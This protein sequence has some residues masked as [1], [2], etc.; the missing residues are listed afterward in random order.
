MVYIAYFTE[1]SSKIWDYAQKRRICRGNC[2]YAFDDN[3]HGHF[4]PWRKAVNFCHPAKYS[5]KSSSSNLTIQISLLGIFY[6]RK[7]RRCKKSGPWKAPIGHTAAI[8]WGHVAPWTCLAAW[9]GLPA[10]FLQGPLPCRV[11]NQCAKMSLLCKEAVPS[12]AMCYIFLWQLMCV[13]R[14]SL[15]WECISFIVAVSNAS[16][17]F[18]C[19]LW[20]HVIHAVS[21]LGVLAGAK[22]HFW[23]IQA[24]TALC[25]CAHLCRPKYSLQILK[26][27]QN[28]ISHLRNRQNMDGAKCSRMKNKTYPWN[29]AGNIILQHRC[30]R[31][32]ICQ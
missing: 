3:F 5:P 28:S 26:N 7:L 19:S 25:S 16:N 27:I 21:V 1:L 20:K 22:E 2:K 9:L 29:P 32:C 30:R 8:K 17:H 11:Y 18:V 23:G 10:H 12:K 6:T 31:T 13:L 24:Q 14:P 15:F 4:C